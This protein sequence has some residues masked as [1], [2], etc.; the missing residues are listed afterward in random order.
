VKR[1]GIP[2]LILGYGLLSA[3]FYCSLL[4]LWEG[5]DELYHYGYVQHLSVT[6]TFPV[7]GTTTL[8]RE[9]WTSIDY[10]PVSHY[11][12]PYLARPST[13]FQDYF[14][15]PEE[16][17]AA[18]RRGLEAIPR[19]L[20]GESS[21]RANY[22][23]KQA[24]ATYVL[25]ALFDRLLSSTPLP[26]RVLALRLLLA[27]PSMILLWTGAR[28][29]ARR[30]GLP[31]EM[32]AAALFLIFSCQM[33]YGTAC[34]VANDALLIPWLVIFLNAAIDSWASPGRR[35][36]A[37]AA[38]L[39]ALGVLLKASAL[40]FLPL[41]FAGPLAILVRRKGGLLE[42]A[43]LAAVTVGI[44]IGVAGPWYLRNVMLYH[45]VTATLDTTTGVG[46]AE[47]WRAAVALPWLDSITYMAHAALWTGNSSFTNFSAHTLDVVLALLALVA[48]MY[49]LRFRRSAAEAITLV[50]IVLYCIE[51]AG[52]T[53][54]FFH[55]SKGAVNAAM[56]WYMQILLA[57]VVLLCLAGLARWGRWARWLAVALVLLWGYVAAATWV[58]KL[59]PLY[60][61]FDDPHARP[62]Q[63][64]AWYFGDAAQRDSILRY[65]SPGPLPLLYVLFFAVL[66][67]LAIAAAVV[68]RK[69]LS[70]ARP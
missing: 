11:L 1:S 37:A 66:C 44:L 7:I 34:H 32:E 21:P 42:A 68:V 69:S 60:G 62:R 14:R 58:A 39:M 51:M 55:S 35:R 65:L 49:C 31:S 23:V 16:E 47:L 52:I 27:I 67:T 29:L 10:A 3:V 24:P 45:N 6:G 56:P 33:L 36:I 40:I 43:K 26:W 18:R 63:L 30:L 9:L 50:A 12:Q 59:V 38:I 15:L 41:V 20:A 61:G 5:F 2:I 8:S 13:S 25:L 70:S 22:E 48:A 53:L 19:A 17:R 46:A 4:P 64:I 57:P 28:G 54:S